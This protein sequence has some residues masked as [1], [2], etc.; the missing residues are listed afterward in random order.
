MC[1]HKEDI[2]NEIVNN[3]T[4]LV[5]YAHMKNINRLICGKDRRVV[6][7][8]DILKTKAINMFEK[9]IKRKK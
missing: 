6:I 3:I 1:S 4:K 9:R 7:T 2:I 5:L 8:D